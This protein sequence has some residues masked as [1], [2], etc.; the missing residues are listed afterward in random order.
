MSAHTDTPRSQ[1]YS[2][3]QEKKDTYER[4]LSLRGSWHIILKKKNSQSAGC[5]KHKQACTN[6][7]WCKRGR[8]GGASAAPEDPDPPLVP[9]R[10]G[11]QDSEVNCPTGAAVSHPDQPGAR[12]GYPWRPRGTAPIPFG[13]KVLSRRLPRRWLMESHHRLQPR[14]GLER[15]EVSLRTRTGNLSIGVDSGNSSSSS[16]CFR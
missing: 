8:R 15:R 3:M 5:N 9:P 2:H 7:C 6:V 10:R 13:V 1:Q 12:A 16:L 4:S 14:K 11:H